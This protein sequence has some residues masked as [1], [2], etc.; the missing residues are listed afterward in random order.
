MPR[1]IG[2]DFGTTNTRIHLG[3]TNAPERTSPLQPPNADRDA[4][5]SV[6]LIDPTGELLEELGKPAVRALLDPARR[7][8]VRFEFKPC[9]GRSEQDLE[10][11]MESLVLE[12]R[13]P[14]CEAKIPEGF[15]FC[16]KCG[17]KLPDDYQQT[18][19][20]RALRYEREEAFGYAALLLAEVGKFLRRTT[21]G[22]SGWDAGDKIVI[23]VPVHWSEETRRQYA[24][25]VAKA[26]GTDQVEPVDEP[27]AALA[28]YLWRAAGEVHAGDTVLVVDVGGG[29]TDL[30]AGVV[31]ED[32]TLGGDVRSHGIRYGGADFDDRVVLWAL[33]QVELPDGV[34]EDQLAG[35][36]RPVCRSLKEELSDAIRR[37]PGNSS[38][39]VEM[40]FTSRELYT[41]LALDRA[42]FESEEVAGPLIGL[43][44]EALTKGLAEMGL[45]AEDVAHVI[46]VG[47]GSNAYFVE[48]VAKAILKN[49][50]VVAGQQPEVAISRGLVLVTAV[51]PMPTAKVV[52]AED[53]MSGTAVTV[54]TVL[55]VELDEPEPQTSTEPKPMDARFSEAIRYIRRLTER[56]KNRKDIEARLLEAGWTKDDFEAVWLL[57]SKGS[58]DENA[59]SP[60]ALVVTPTTATGLWGPAEAFPDVVELLEA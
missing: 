12:L 11:Q 40:P 25:L 2:L 13:C 32:G 57:A 47:G 34:D 16:G 59:A 6:I 10:K 29:T 24:A 3:F 36:L 27:R 43:F 33:R 38:H 5:P 58:A 48:D 4:L 46:L 23:G 52:A 35:A 15:T 37:D 31:Q 53:A 22:D 9:L 20:E 54:E 39:R 55:L 8:R 19:A 49:A 60:P 44:A 28:E 26:L 56:G 7:D 14:T 41:D 45:R 17:N 30:V 21:L 42:T 50:R 1:I 51:Q 18:L